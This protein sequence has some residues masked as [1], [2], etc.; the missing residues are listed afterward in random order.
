M[1]HDENQ[2]P[3][4]KEEYH[5][6]PRAA[7]IEKWNMVY[8][9]AARRREHTGIRPAADG[10]HQP[11]GKNQS[12][13]PPRAAPSLQEHANAGAVCDGVHR[14]QARRAVAV[15]D[16]RVQI[17]GAESVHRANEKTSP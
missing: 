13:L 15:N 6:S 8:P 9:D 11:G 5:E 2:I 7:K 1:R 10:V 4:S 17:H 16:T 3:Y 14:R 12:R